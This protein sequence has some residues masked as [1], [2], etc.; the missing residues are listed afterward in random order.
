MEKLIAALLVAGATIA[1]SGCTVGGD[2][3]AAPAPRPTTHA[4]TST[5][6][7]AATPAPT[8]SVGPVVQPTPAPTTNAPYDSGWRF[9][10]AGYGPIEL[11]KDATVVLNDALFTKEPS[12]CIDLYHWSSGNGRTSGKQ[13]WELTVG[14]IGNR[15][16][17]VYAAVDSKEAQP[18]KIDGEARTDTGITF[19]STVTDLKAA[20]PGIQ[21]TND[22]WDPRYGGYREWTLNATGGVLVF[23]TSGGEDSDHD[24]VTSIRAATSW[25]HDAAGDIQPLC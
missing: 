22:T 2:D 5:P 25:G 11:G 20:Y 21:K 4:A 14:Q 3:R 15:V 23:N 10:T 1:L 8:P 17:Y 6:A 18:E 24:W 16:R 12:G 19:G 9:T 13:E 7:P